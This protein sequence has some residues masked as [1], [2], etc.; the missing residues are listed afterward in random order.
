MDRDELVQRMVLSRICDDYENVDQSILPEVAENASGL[1]FTIERADVIN[2][3]SNLVARGLAKCYIISGAEPFAAEL[4]G[5]PS[6]DVAEQNHRTFFLAT[7]EGT[8]FDNSNDS[9]LP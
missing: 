6:L 9:W 8:V 1:G 4:E 2:A 5:M 3:L 7:H